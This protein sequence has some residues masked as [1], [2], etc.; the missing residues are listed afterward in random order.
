MHAAPRRSRRRAMAPHAF[1]AARRVVAT[2]AGHAHCADVVR[3]HRPA[4][5]RW[6]L[7]IRPGTCLPPATRHPP[8]ATR[9]PALA[10]RPRPPGAGLPPS[11]PARTRPSPSAL[12][13]GPRTSTVTRRSPSAARHPPRH[14][15]HVSPRWPPAPGHSPLASGPRTSP[16]TRRWLF[17]PGHPALAARTRARPTP[18]CP[19][20][21]PAPGSH[22]RRLPRPRA[23]LPRIAE[24]SYLA[25]IVIFGAPLGRAGGRAFRTAVRRR[26][27]P[28]SRPPPATRP[29]G[30][31]PSPAPSRPHHRRNTAA[32]ADGESPGRECAPPDALAARPYGSALRVPRKSPTCR[33]GSTSIPTPIA[34]PSLGHPTTSPPPR[35]HPPPSRRAP[36]Q[37]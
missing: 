35:R 20:R 6:P 9:H 21:V 11:P 1:A 36:R 31:R 32:P 24:M 28:A 34:P 27:L 5:R 18:H 29:P 33:C 13:S 15:P 4:T 10:V 19:P 23:K 8:H 22:R 26:P 3:G 12:A 16:A 17:A 2:R 30:A 7:A 14:P 25:R 37:P